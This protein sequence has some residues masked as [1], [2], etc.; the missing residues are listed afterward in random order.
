MQRNLPSPVKGSVNATKKSSY[1]NNL[2]RKC[3]ICRNRGRECPSWEYK[4][5]FKLTTKKKGVCHPSRRK[6]AQALSK[7]YIID[8][9]GR[10]QEF[11][12][13]RIHN[14]VNR[15][16]ADVFN[17]DMPEDMRDAIDGH[18]G[19][20]DRDNAELE[21]SIEVIQD[22]VEILLMQKGYYDVAKSYILYR[23][24]HTENRLLSERFAFIEK[25][26]HSTE[27]AATSSET[28]PNANVGMKNIANLNGE[29]FKP[30]YRMLQRYIMK[31]TLERMY[32]EVA[33]QY[34]KD[35]EHR[36]I[37]PHDEASYPV[38]TY[39]CKAASLWPFTKYG[40]G[41][42]D[43]LG[44]TAPE[45]LSSFA[46]QFGNLVF[47]LSSQCRGAVAYGELWNVLDHFCVKEFGED[48]HRRL[49]E[50]VSL[51]PRMTILEA[52]HQC[53]QQ[54]TYTMNQPAGNRCF[55]SPFTNVSY[56]DSFYWHALFKDFSFADGTKPSWER[57]SF[58][59]KCYMKWFNRERERTMLTFPVETMA[60]L[61]EKGRL[62]DEEYRQFTA[63]MYAEGHSFFTYM[64]NNPNGLAS[65]CRLRNEI[66]E[67]VFSFT[68]GL[69]GVQTG[70]A[71]VITLNHSRIIQDWARQEGYTREFLKDH[72]FE[73][74]DSYAA[75]LTAILERVYKYQKAYK[76]I[77]YDSEALGL[78]SASNEGYISMSKLF[79][80]IGDNGINE[81]AEFVGLR[82]SYNEDY[83]QFCSIITGTIRKQN[84]LHSSLRFKFNQELVPAESLSSKNLNWDREDGYWVPEGRILYNSYFYLADDPETTVLD[85]FLLHG[86]E[87][88]ETLDGGVG[89]HC[90]LE[91]HLDKE[92]YLM[93][94]DFAAEHGT[95]YFTFNVP[96]SECKNREC[97][98]IVK[99]PVR[100]CPV[101]GSDMR[102]WTRIIGY[103][104]PLE[105]FEEARKREALLRHMHKKEEDGLC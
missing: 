50:V 85:K 101:C 18:F 65:C 98:H 104:R 71:N 23:H 46:G 49:D 81:A 76:S 53:F 12:I 80:T 62:K 67:N 63:E 78:F 3:Y 72:F 51:M 82:C 22:R 96:N 90:N 35:I 86:R 4:Q 26:R 5:A 32:P 84:K 19:Q 66:D 38:P 55:Q 77:L 34:E 48:Y 91:E 10:R 52:I 60:L 8:R 25:Y 99:K 2:F 6:A 79:L 95:S 94:L 28:D 93:L 14:A 41:G 31:K 44:T 36:I 40:T 100:K 37:Y 27:N 74:K 73:V 17:H 87:F 70:S 11:D 47:L 45:H 7:M 16:F 15:A 83:K 61:T 24:E 89:L 92:Q 39:Y 69:T 9:N 56:Y 88:T 105:N 68:N 1:I 97:R 58:I 42:L 29:V 20:Y 30:Q 75:Y 64:S 33:D 54:I 59:Q 43:G 57:V 21:I 13:R 102:W 103:L